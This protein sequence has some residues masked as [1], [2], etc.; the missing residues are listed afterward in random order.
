MRLDGPQLENVEGAEGK[1]SS[2][3]S[4]SSLHRSWSEESSD[5][6][7]KHGT[8]TGTGTGHCS[9][10]PQLFIAQN[11]RSCLLSAALNC[12]QPFL[13]SRFIAAVLFP[14]PSFCPPTPQPFFFLSN[15]QPFTYSIEQNLTSPANADIHAD[16]TEED[17]KMEN[18]KVQRDRDY[19]AR[20][21]R[22]M[23]SPTTEGPTLSGRRWVGPVLDLVKDPLRLKPELKHDIL[24]GEG[25]WLQQRQ[26]RQ[27]QN[28]D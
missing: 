28:S 14:P 23:Q 12:P 27:Q 8:G 6:L 11:V 3:H 24:T 22:S 19:G 9:K 21:E 4:C 10:C 5:T 17:D 26:Q 25:P 13:R 2:E 15:T 7:A 20:H 18:G 1:R 16:Y